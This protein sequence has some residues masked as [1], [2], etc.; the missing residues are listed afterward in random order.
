M[1][2]CHDDG[3][4][5]GYLEGLVEDDA[6]GHFQGHVPLRLRALGVRDRDSVQWVRYVR[7]ACE[8]GWR[9]PLLRAPAGTTF[10]PSVIVA[11]ERFEDAARELWK[12]HVDQTGPAPDGGCDVFLLVTLKG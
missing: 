12:R 3:T 6:Q 7:A 2:W 8:C 10:H 4:H 11:P 9:S 5:E 1:G